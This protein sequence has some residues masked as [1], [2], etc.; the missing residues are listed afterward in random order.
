MTTIA[1]A[2]TVRPANVLVISSFSN[3]AGSFL[4]YI[5]ASSA[6]VFANK[7]IYVNYDFQASNTLLLAQMVPIQNPLLRGQF[8]SLTQIFT[9]AVLWVARWSDL[10]RF[11]PLDF[12]TARKIAPVTLFY[13]LNAAVALMSL[14]FLNVA[15]CTIVFCCLVQFSASQ[16]PSSNA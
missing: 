4:F 15:A 10:I 11:P 14:R 2:G 1:A 3:L 13:T 16:I 8:V 12:A 9:I 5:V 6:M 7:A